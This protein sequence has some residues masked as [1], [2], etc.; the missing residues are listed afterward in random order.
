MSFPSSRREMLATAAA[1]FIGGA[2]QSARPHLVLFLSDDHGW[3][4]SSVF[5][6]RVVRTPNLQRVAGEG[7]VF[8]H[9]YTGAAI[10]IPSRGIIASGLCSHRN[11][12][13][14]NGRS[15]KPEIRTIA[16][17]MSEAGYR[18]AHFGKS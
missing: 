14:A 4:D 10:C 18:V 2:Q 15:M 16:S 11:G 13:I 8:E 12:A 17:Y 1:P 7:T 6:S 9:A 3:R 5:G